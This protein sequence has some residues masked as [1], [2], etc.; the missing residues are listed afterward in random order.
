MLESLILGIT[1]GIAEWLPVSSEGL[2]FLIKSNFFNRGESLVEITQ[3]ALWLHL[4]TFLAALIYFRH[5]VIKLVKALFKFKSASVE[6]Q[7]TLKFLII[8]TLISGVLG[9]LLLWLISEIEV[10]IET[11]IGVTTKIVTLVIGILLLVTAFLQLKAKSIGLRKTEDLRTSDGIIL[12]V[13]QGL[14]VLP[15]LSRSGLT[16]SSLLLLKI[17]SELALKLSFLMSLPIVLGGN[18]IL[19]LEKFSLGWDSFISLFTSFIFGYLTINILLKI[20]KKINFGW[21]VLGFGILMILAY[22]I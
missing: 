17:N 7:N 3:I 11:S 13:A 20:S 18:I 4:G 9:I 1:Q 15:G 19:N 14:A 22:F 21:F 6:L 5:D 10:T 16:I 12:G 8:S 2:I